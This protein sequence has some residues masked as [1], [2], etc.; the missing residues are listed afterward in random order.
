MKTARCSMRTETMLLM[1]DGGGDCCFSMSLLS[2]FY[3]PRRF[4]TLVVVVVAAV[5]DCFALELTSNTSA[6]FDAV[7]FSLR[8]LLISFFYSSSIV[9]EPILG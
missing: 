4:S 1:S 3:W 8:L 2:R 9:A 7:G 5:D 6:A